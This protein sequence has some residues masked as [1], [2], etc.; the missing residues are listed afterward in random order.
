MKITY[1]QEWFM[2]CNSIKF[3]NGWTCGFLEKDFSTVACF[4]YT[5]KGK[6]NVCEFYFILRVET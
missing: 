2:K 3:A 6:R 5:C 4:L 1:Q